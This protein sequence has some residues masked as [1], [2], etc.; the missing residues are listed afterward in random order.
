MNWWR[1][2]T[3]R[4]SGMLSLVAGLALLALPL[5]APALADEDDSAGDNS[6]LTALV[7]QGSGE[8]NV[9]PTGED[10]G[11]LAA[12]VTVNIHGA[13][14]GTTFNAYRKFDQIADG[15]CGGVYNLV[16]D[17]TLQVSEGGAG[18]T[19]FEI[20]QPLPS[21]RRFDIQVEMRGDDGSVL[22]SDCMT[23]EVK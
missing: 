14:P 8:I 7:G 9:A 1:I 2:R 5:A 10:Q 4:G 12:Q 23:I 18:A 15:V 20:H 17:S 22:Q 6:A 19:H 16:P 13:I 21:D 11:F 3:G